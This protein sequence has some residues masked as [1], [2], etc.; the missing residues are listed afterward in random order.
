MLTRIDSVVLSHP[1][2]ARAAPRQP[3]RADEHTPFPHFH[4]LRSRE[5][6]SDDEAG[7]P[8]GSPDTA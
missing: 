2:E 8:V 5:L 3:F 1:D 6:C 4:G 7:C